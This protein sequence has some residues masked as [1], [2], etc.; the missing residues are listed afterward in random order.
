MEAP[1]Y[2]EIFACL[3][4]VIGLY[5]ILYLKVAV[6]PER[7][8]LIAAVGLT[9]KLLGPVGFSALLLTGMWPLSSAVLILSNDLLWW[10]P[11]GLYLYDSWVFHRAG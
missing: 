3:G 5:G 8:W 2:P 1:R 7:E 4:M 10:I 11:F 6:D 9:G